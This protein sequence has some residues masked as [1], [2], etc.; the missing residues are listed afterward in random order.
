MIPA[1]PTAAPEMEHHRGFQTFAAVCGL[2][3]I[4]A[5]SA[6]PARCADDAQRPSR[7][8]VAPGLGP[9]R[10]GLA[11]KG[12]ERTLHLRID[13]IAVLSRK[14]RAVRADHSPTM[15]HDDYVKAMIA[16]GLRR[17]PAAK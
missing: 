11:T 2:D 14:Q 7:A 15:R 1:L 4:V 6:V 5:T 9:L 13:G 3:R 8:H 17:V 10:T 12:G 16:R